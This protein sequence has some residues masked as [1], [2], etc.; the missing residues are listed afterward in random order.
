MNNSQLLQGDI[1][2]ILKYSDI[3]DFY[4]GIYLAGRARSSMPLPWQVNYLPGAFGGPKK[5]EA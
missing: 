3:F 5:R 2:T 1:E 4:S